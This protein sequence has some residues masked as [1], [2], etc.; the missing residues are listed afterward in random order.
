MPVPEMLDIHLS[1][2]R[3]FPVAGGPARLG[4]EPHSQTGNYTQG[5]TPYQH[6]VQTVLV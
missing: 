6:Q 3:Q 4:R 1:R 5:E 2:L